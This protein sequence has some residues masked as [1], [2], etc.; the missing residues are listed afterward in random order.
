VGAGAGTAS[1]DASVPAAFASTMQGTENGVLVATAFTRE[2]ILLGD[3][4]PD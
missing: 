2:F 3:V 4:V 1:F